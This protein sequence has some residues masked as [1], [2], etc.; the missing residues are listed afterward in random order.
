M[1]IEQFVCSL[2]DILGQKQTLE[3]LRCCEKD[4]KSNI[5]EIYDIFSKTYKNIERFR[6][7]TSHS[8]D[9]VNKLK[10]KHNIDT[11]II[12]NPIE[13]KSFSDLITSYVSI[14]F[15]SEKKVQFQGIYF[16]LF[17]NCMTFLQMLS[18]G[19]PLRGG[20]DIGIGIKTE[21]NEIYG[22]ALVKAYNLET[23]VATSIRLVIGKDLYNYIDSISKGEI[24]SNEIT[25]YNIAYAKLCQNIIIQDCDGEYILD[26]LSEEFKDMENFDS[27]VSKAKNFLKQKYEKN[28]DIQSV[29]KKYL[30]ALK[31]FESKGQ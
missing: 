30:R 3:T 14:R 1:K 27:F 11:G 19:I 7:Y 16:L 20:I 29:S 18:D 12:S 21:E 31:Y 17:S 2:I 8:T 9:F 25:D 10:N 23:N 5:Y 28:K 24:E 4:F 13:I 22:N 15:D 6:A 26:Y